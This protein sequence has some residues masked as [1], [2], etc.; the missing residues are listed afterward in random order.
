MLLWQALHY[1]FISSLC[2]SLEL[3]TFIQIEY[4]FCSLSRH[5]KDCVINHDAMEDS[6][7]LCDT[8][9]QRAHKSQG[10]SPCKVPATSAT[11]SQHYFY[12]K[13]KK[14]TT[15]IQSGDFN[16]L[17]L[18]RQGHRWFYAYSISQNTSLS[19]NMTVLKN[20]SFVQWTTSLLQIVR[21]AFQPSYLYGNETSFQR[22]MFPWTPVAVH[23]TQTSPLKST[24]LGLRY[25]WLAPFHKLFY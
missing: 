25:F 3:M 1:H 15:S 11:I 21:I 6:I 19:T 16:I 17:C 12:K 2:K 23:W 5:L 18:A 8:V 4:P 13:K 24:H 22:G 7:A 20:N 9:P 10:S 14:I